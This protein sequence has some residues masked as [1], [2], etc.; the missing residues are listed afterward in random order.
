MT[1]SFYNSETMWIQNHKFYIGDR[2]VS[3]IVVDDVVKLDTIE[4]I[5]PVRAT[6]NSCTKE[7]YLTNQIISR[8]DLINK[9]K[10]AKRKL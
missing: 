10:H 3:V 4:L 6:M 5:N 1:E 8:T 7:I 2:R 9:L